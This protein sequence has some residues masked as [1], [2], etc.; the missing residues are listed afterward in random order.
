MGYSL[1]IADNLNKV[2]G[3][4]A[5]KDKITF[6][7]INK[8]VSEILE[9]PYLPAMFITELIQIGKAMVFHQSRCLN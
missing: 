2:F 1:E 7:A 4:L 3:K 8:K 6:Q 9:N 5:N